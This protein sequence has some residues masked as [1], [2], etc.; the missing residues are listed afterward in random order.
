MPPP[1]LPPSYGAPNYP[2]P[3]YQYPHVPPPGTN[4]LAIG[5]LVVSLVSAFVCCG[6]LG[7]VGAIMGHVARGQIRATG[8]Q[9]DG[10]A[11][12]GIII[13]WLTTLLLLAGVLVWVGLL[14]VTA[15]GY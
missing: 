7:F 12:A 8:E 14:G 1:Q 6:A 13:G 9:G 4:G 15:A 2:P 11:L 3:G 10:I 5:S